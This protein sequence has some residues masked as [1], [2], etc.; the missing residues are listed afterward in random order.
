MIHDAWGMWQLRSHH[1]FHR[2][3]CL[4]QAPSRADR[5]R[6]A[7]EGRGLLAATSQLASGLPRA[8]MLRSARPSFLPRKQR[9]E[10]RSNE[11]CEPLWLRAWATA[12]Q[13]SPLPSSSLRMSRAGVAGL[14]RIHKS[15]TSMN[16][17]RFEDDRPIVRSVSW[18]LRSQNQS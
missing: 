13:S 14:T 4:L 9:L 8:T 1:G 7:C 11:A 3:R 5:S 12:L 17:E 16:G 6:G 10:L 2:R 18:T 15:S